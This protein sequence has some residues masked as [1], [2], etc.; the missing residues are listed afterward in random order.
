MFQNDQIILAT[1]RTIETNHFFNPGY[2]NM[3]N[4]LDANESTNSDSWVNDH[5]DYI[6]LQRL[7]SGYGSDRAE[8]VGRMMAAE[9]VKQVVITAIALK[10][11]QLKHGNHPRNLDALVPE[12]LA[13]VPFDPVDGRALRYRLNRDGTYL[14]YSVG[15]NG[16]D[17][18]GNPSLASG[19]TGPNFYWLGPH[20][21]DWV[22]PQPATKA[23]I[24]YF[25]AHPPK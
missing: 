16:K 24:E 19:I 2:S 18:G 12:F 6:G 25:Y 5:I 7:F 8:P 1:I 13:A 11:Y 23:E 22:W 20:A 10:R 14:L 4:Q 3:M 21:L 9:V 15:E 17:D